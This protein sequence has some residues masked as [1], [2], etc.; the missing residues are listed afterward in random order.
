ML[1][2]MVCNESGTEVAE[3]DLKKD[4]EWGS[5]IIYSIRCVGEVVSI[6]GELGSSFW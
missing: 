1:M 4:G 6:E 2:R 3:V 5:K